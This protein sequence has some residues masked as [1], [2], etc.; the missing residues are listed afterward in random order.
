MLKC[1]LST[2]SQPWLS[3]LHKECIASIR[4]RFPVPS[5]N[6]SKIEGAPRDCR[7][8]LH[9]V[10]FAALERFCTALGRFVSHPRLRL[11]WRHHKRHHGV[12]SRLALLRGLGR[13]SAHLAAAPGQALTHETRFDTPWVHR[14]ALGRHC[15][16]PIDQRQR[17][18]PKHVCTDFL[19]RRE[20]EGGGRMAYALHIVLHAK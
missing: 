4:T 5:T 16:L 15:D 12:R 14:L 18:T 2:S 11:A 7:A 13:H 1:E 9:A 6:F 17:G 3:S 19:D 8:H 10:R 20:I